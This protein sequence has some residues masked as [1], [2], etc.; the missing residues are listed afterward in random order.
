MVFVGVWTANGPFSVHT[1]TVSSG[2]SVDPILAFLFIVR[3]TP[4]SG[5]LFIG[6]WTTI[7]AFSVGT[8]TA[9][10][11]KVGPISVDDSWSSDICW[12]PEVND[13]AG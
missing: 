13:I 6:G 3:L 10:G 11:T 9:V 2:A 8:A 1:D 4:I 12:G 7:G 5:I